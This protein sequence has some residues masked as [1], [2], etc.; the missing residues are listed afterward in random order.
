LRARYPVLAAATLAVLWTALVLWLYP[1]EG[2]AHIAF[3]VAFGVLGGA[4]FYWDSRIERT[5]APSTR[6][7]IAQAVAFSVLV[8]VF[9]WWSHPDKGMVRT[10]ALI[11]VGPLLGVA[12]YWLT[13][14]RRPRA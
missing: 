9:M 13:G 14:R 8:T 2:V 7:R 11:V 6:T 4:F 5:P 1:G 3:V 12:W 10:V